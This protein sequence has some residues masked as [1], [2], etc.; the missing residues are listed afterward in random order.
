MR[1][2]VF[3]RRVQ[4]NGFPVASN[5]PCSDLRRRLLQPG[6]FVRVEDLLHANAAARAMRRF[7]AAVQAVVPHALAVAVARQ[8]I[9]DV[10]NL[11]RQQISLGLVRILKRVAPEL[12]FREYLRLV[13]LRRTAVVCRNVVGLGKAYRRQQRYEDEWS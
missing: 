5:H 7:E 1:S 12:V 8:L 3:R 6:L 2:V 11:R 9:N 4:V 10:G 13:G